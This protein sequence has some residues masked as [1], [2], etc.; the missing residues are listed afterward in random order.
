MKRCEAIIGRADVD[1][2]KCAHYRK[3]EG[4]DAVV[5]KACTACKMVYYCNVTC[6]K[7][8]RKQH[9]RACK[10]CAAELHDKA[11]FRTPVSKKPLTNTNNY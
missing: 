10:K 1:G 5:L 9:R 11:L 3:K 7:A 4:E 6:Q 8:H 2:K